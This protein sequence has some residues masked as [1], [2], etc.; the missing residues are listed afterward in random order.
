MIAK[1]VQDF[2]VSSRAEAFTR[3][4]QISQTV[5]LVPVGNW[6][7]HDNNLVSLMCKWRAENKESF[8]AQIEPDTRSMLN[9]LET[10]SIR[11]ERTLLFI[12]FSEGHPLGHLGLSHI[13]DGSAS[14]DQVMKGVREN[15][16]S[17]N[18]GLMKSAV[19][20]L[21]DWSRSNLGLSVL[22]L[23][24]VSSNDSAI[25]LYEK[26]NFVVTQKFPLKAI[27]T[28]GGVFLKEENALE[29]STLHKLSMRLEL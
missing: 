26:C 11:D 15:S 23:D 7:L 27:Q 19:M 28:A 24:V 22:H 25:K 20:A 2:K 21:I 18:K 8:F 1:F 3:S 12:I 4:I 10:H 13:K 6:I 9:Y 5:H 17:R 14:L 29:N 16:E